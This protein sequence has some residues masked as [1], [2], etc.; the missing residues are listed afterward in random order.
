ML[1][2]APM[3][4]R[5]LE[6]VWSRGGAP[7]ESPFDALLRA[8]DEDPEAAEGFA[9]AYAAM[10]RVERERLIDTV[11]RDAQAAARSPAGPLMLLLAVEEEHELAS[12]IAGALLALGEETLGRRGLDAG[13]VWGG[14]LAGGVAL[15][16]HLHGGFVELLRV[17]WSDG[18]LEV[19]SE[20]L[21][22]ERELAE[23]RRRAGVPTD[24]D[25]VPLE[26]AIDRLAETLWRVRRRGDPWP[27]RLRAFA[28]LFAPYRV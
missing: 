8:A 26:R 21:A 28:D 13:W 12:H 9:L 10:G 23:V 18:R 22:H 14:E 11:V 2:I 3:S 7:E 4:D 20:P 17:G 25:Q 27:E 16:R 6:L 24:A 19:E 5:K 1:H 15:A